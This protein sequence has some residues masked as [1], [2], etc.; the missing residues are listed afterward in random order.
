MGG[1]SNAG[2]T[3]SMHGG[4]ANNVYAAG[5]VPLDEDGRP[6]QGGVGVG[7]V[8]GNLPSRGLGGGGGAAS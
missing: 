6:V 1:A 4:G 5:N 2:A 8:P 3:M 7:L